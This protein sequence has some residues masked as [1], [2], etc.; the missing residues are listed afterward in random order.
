MIERLLAP[1]SR[2][3]RLVTVLDG[4]PATLSWLGA[5]RGHPTESLGVEHF[6][7]TG[8]IPDLYRQ[9]RIDQAAITQAG[10]STLPKGRR[11]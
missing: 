8:T 6:G 10:L 3:T 2:H 1:L 4:H 5:V 7:Q 9:Y 11:R